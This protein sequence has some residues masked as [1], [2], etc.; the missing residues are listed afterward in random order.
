MAGFFPDGPHVS[1]FYVFHI[2]V[3]AGLFT[4]TLDCV[5]YLFIQVLGYIVIMCYMFLYIL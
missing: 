2:C 4:S 3:N 1:D 5:L